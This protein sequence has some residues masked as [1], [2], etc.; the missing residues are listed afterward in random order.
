MELVELLKIAVE[1]KASD[2]HIKVGMPPVLRIDHK[3]VP[4][5]EL[6]R[7]GRAS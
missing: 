3:L 6:P 4:L 5:M 7:L 1:R 2:L